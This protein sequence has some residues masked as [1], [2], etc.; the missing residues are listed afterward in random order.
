[1]SAKDSLDTLLQT[2]VNTPETEKGSV[3][4]SLV[5]ALRESCGL[6]KKSSTEY[7]ETAKQVQE[8]LDSI[9][10][11]T[12]QEEEWEDEFAES[13]DEEI[14]VTTSSAPP[15]PSGRTLI[16]KP[17]AAPRPP[18]PEPVPE[19]VVAETPLSRLLNAWNHVVGNWQKLPDA[20]VA[21]PDTVV[22][23]IQSIAAL[24]SNVLSNPFD[25]QAGTLTRVDQLWA[26]LVGIF[27]E[28]GYKITPRSFT[29]I[30]NPQGRIIHTARSR[31]TS[32]ET[33]LLCPGICHYDNLLKDAIWV[34]S[35]PQEGE[36][37]ANSNHAAWP[38]HW[39]GIFGETEILLEHLK[40][41]Q[42]ALCSVE[43][44]NKK[45]EPFDEYRDNLIQELQRRL[46]VLDATIQKDSDSIYRVATDYWR[47]EEFFWS[48]FHEDDRPSGCSAFDRLKNR[49]QTWRPV[50]R[51][52]LKFH[53]RDFTCG[54]ESLASVNKY[55]G[56]IIIS[57]KPNTTTGMVI[58]ELRPAIAVPV[59]GTNRLLK[60]RVIAT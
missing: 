34:I 42:N 48:I 43:G 49:I 33:E 54:S 47:V 55:I 26:S 52:L 3:V 39:R 17:A 22:K 58:R 18:A 29:D 4:Y 53:I 38:S 10:S 5:K 31:V 6:F 8:I 25:D 30:S 59:Q 27:Q 19:P 24:R 16:I 41:Q 35:F 50:L 14:E 9:L 13:S 32:P 2:L 21:K 7:Q 28:N 1:M 15:K 56:N 46:E 20:D 60:G 11:E 12:I 51:R 44:I 40:I 36:F 37:P 45:V 23:L 57:T